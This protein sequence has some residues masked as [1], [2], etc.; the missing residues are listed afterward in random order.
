MSKREIYIFGFRGF[1]N[2]QG[3]VETHVENLAPH[4]KVI[5]C[6]L[7]QI[8]VIFLFRY[9]GRSTRYFSPIDFGI[10]I[11]RHG[12]ELTDARSDIE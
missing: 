10:R 1:P 2:V 7:K 12:E 5:D 6:T 9:L 11:A 3:G 4:V 8:Q